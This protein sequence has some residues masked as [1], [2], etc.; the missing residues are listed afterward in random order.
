MPLRFTLREIFVRGNHNP[1]N[2]C[3]WNP[4]SG[5]FFFWNLESWLW[6]LESS[7]RLEFGIQVQL[8]MNLE[9]DITSNSNPEC[10]IQNPRLSWIIACIC[11]HDGHLSSRNPLKRSAK[12]CMVSGKVSKN[13]LCFN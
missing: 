10:G 9:S 11:S 6:N 13:W 2:F 5:L 3:L 7:Y 1:R 8:K 4:E 12:I